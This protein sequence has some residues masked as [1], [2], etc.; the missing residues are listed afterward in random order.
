[1]TNIKGTNLIT[2]NAES[3][4]EYLIEYESGYNVNILNQTDGVITISPSADYAGDENSSEC[5][6]LT[7]DAFYY[8][9]CSRLS[10][11][12]YIASAGDGL[13]SVVRTDR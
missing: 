13:I 8:D 7:E 2:I 12:L 4:E 6:K 1:M 5:L 3:G 9:L 11:A 10:K